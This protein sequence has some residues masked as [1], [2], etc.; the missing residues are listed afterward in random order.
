MLKQSTQEAVE[1]GAFG[2]PFLAF[3]KRD[4]KIEGFFGSDRF[5]LIAD[6]FGLNWHGPVPNPDA[7][8]ELNEIPDQKKL[9]LNLEQFDELQAATHDPN[10]KV[11]P[12]DLL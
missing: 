5:E 11:D 4:S 2:L 10:Q 3:E 1:D 7:L 8:P 9:F 6:R 12:R